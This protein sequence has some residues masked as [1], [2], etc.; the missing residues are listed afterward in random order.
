M[1]YIW[2]LY[3]HPL[4]THSYHLLKTSR[5]L[6]PALCET[7]HPKAAS[8][9]SPAH[10]AHPNARLLL[11]IA[12]VQHHTNCS[13]LLFQ[14]GLQSCWAQTCIFP[15]SISTFPSCIIIIHRIGSPLSTWRAIQ[16]HSMIL[17][18]V[19]LAAEIFPLCKGAIKILLNKAVVEGWKCTFLY[20]WV[21]ILFCWIFTQNQNY[22]EL[23]KNTFVRERALGLYNISSGN[24]AITL[25]YL[26][27]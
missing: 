27:I 11:H 2:K 15:Q 9:A 19:P 18:T 21:W 20:S 7:K 16:S 14:T 17:R 5:M 6:P 13:K 8:C 4:K 22:N 1:Y 24:M 25:F 10:S 12:H 26:K 23:L 3:N